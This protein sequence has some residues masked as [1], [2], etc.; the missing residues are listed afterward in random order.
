MKVSPKLTPYFPSKSSTDF[1][2]EC[3][4]FPLKSHSPNKTSAIPAPSEP[5]NPAATK[6]SDSNLLSN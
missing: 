4:N 1:G 5:G 3:G 6:T 2:Q